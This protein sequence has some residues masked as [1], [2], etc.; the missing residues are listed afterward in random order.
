MGRLPNPFPVSYAFAK[1]TRAAR[2]PAMAACEFQ[3]LISKRI[4]TLERKINENLPCACN[5]H[6]CRYFGLILPNPDPEE[7]H[8]AGSEQ[9]LPS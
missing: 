5:Q 7:H 2:S 6:P 3:T 8:V 9:F 1:Y 4:P